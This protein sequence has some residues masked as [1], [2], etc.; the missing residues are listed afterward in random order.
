[1]LIERHGAEFEAML[2]PTPRFSP[3][4]RDGA[5]SDTGI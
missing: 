3:P 5:R 1:M 4:Q 2:S